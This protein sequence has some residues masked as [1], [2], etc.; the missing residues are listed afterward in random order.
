MK[1]QA[2]MAAL[3]VTT[4]SG[5]DSA[6]TTPIDANGDGDY[7]DPGDW[8]PGARAR[9]RTGAKPRTTAAARARR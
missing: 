6:F 8:M 2:Q 3:G 1:N 5:Y 7:T 4:Q 9:S